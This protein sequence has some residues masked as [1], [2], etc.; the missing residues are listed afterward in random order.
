MPTIDRLRERHNEYVKQL[1]KAV[2]RKDKALDA[3]IKAEAKV[4]ALIKAVARS[5]KRLDKARSLAALNAGPVDRSEPVDLGS[6][7]PKEAD[8]EIAKA[9]LPVFDFVER[10]MAAQKAVDVE[11]AAANK[12]I[13][14]KAKASDVTDI[15]LSELGMTDH[16][17]ANAKSWNAIPAVAKAKRRA[18]R[19]PDDFKAEI[20]GRKGSATRGRIAD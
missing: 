10:G 5:A 19:T 14:S 16:G 8:A 9:P 17:K 20:A 12:R 4:R 1:A 6:L 3:L 18:R 7:T 13:A 11:V 2:A 15:P